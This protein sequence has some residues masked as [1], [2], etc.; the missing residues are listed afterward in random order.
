MSI[1]KNIE[2]DFEGFHKQIEKLDGKEEQMAKTEVSFQEFL[3][4]KKRVRKAPSALT[5]MLSN[6]PELAAFLSSIGNGYGVGSSK[7]AVAIL[8][9]EMTRARMAK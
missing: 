8:K 6:E 4:P 7:V 5:I 3:A 1:F 2:K 9:A